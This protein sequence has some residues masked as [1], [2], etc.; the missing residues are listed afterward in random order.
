[1]KKF[2]TGLAGLYSCCEDVCKQLVLTGR[3]P[4]HKV[5]LVGDVYVGANIWIASGFDLH[6]EGTGS[7]AF[8]RRFSHCYIV[9]DY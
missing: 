4:Q 1:M 6:D 3:E 2:C 8:K 5:E 9:T 7:A